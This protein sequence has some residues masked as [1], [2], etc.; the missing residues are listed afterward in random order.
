MKLLITT[1]IR[2]GCNTSFTFSRD[3]GVIE[4]STDFKS[5]F[6]DVIYSCITLRMHSATS[7]NELCR[8]F[9]NI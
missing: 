4:N 7:I 3:S 6:F 5:V 1:Y 9:N 8:I 2:S